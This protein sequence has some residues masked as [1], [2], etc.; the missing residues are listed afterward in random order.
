[1]Y[2]GAETSNDNFHA[3]SVSGM[4][5]QLSYINFIHCYAGR[6]NLSKG[7]INL[8]QKLKKNRKIRNRK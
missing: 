3:G 8:F 1:M 2:E 7:R 6:I 5:G 4:L